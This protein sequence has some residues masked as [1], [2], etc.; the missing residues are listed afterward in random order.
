MQNNLTLN[1]LV[2]DGQALAMAPADYA[3]QVTRVSVLRAPGTQPV[4]PTGNTVINILVD[5][6]VAATVTLPQASVKQSYAVALAVPAESVLA[7]SVVQNGGAADLAV[8]FELVSTATGV[9][10]T[11]FTPDAG[12]FLEDIAAPEYRA[13]TSAAITGGV[14]RIPGLINDTVAELREAIRTGLRNNL[15]PAGTIPSGA[16]HIFMH[17]CK[18]HFFDYIKSV[19]AFAEKCEKAKAQAEK[20]LDAIRKG[21]RLFQ[22]PL[23]IGEAI[24]T[25]AQW[26][27]EPR[28]EL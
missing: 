20:D 10:D 1:G 16:A 12:K 24:T 5:D 21:E 2:T 13:F 7:I 28:I 27:S 17:L 8:W 26:G 11:W 9:A 15:G 14:D 3:Q 19:P 18:W 22:E 25:S 6:A 4:T 23:T